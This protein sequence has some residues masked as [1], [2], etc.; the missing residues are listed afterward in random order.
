MPIPGCENYNAEYFAKRNMSI[1]CDTL[2]EV[3]ENT[4]TLLK[5]KELQE[6]MIENQK[7][8][9]NKNTCDKIIKVVLGE[10]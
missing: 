6:K 4:K 8:N 3:I 7:K 2:N 10:I 9:M 1:K 5:D